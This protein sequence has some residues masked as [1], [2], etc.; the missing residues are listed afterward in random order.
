MLGLGRL[1][2]KY[3]FELIGNN[4]SFE[5]NAEIFNEANYDAA[6]RVKKL[7]LKVA[8]DENPV[9]HRHYIDRRSLSRAM[10]LFLLEK[11]MHS[12]SK[13]W[14][15]DSYSARD[16]TVYN[17]YLIEIDEH[18]GTSVSW[19]GSGASKIGI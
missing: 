3:G 11:E 4:F 2:L 9:M 19:Q 18:D 13:T 6:Q 10:R 1:K 16:D 8:P 14:T 12:L 15:F 5:A 7:K 17:K